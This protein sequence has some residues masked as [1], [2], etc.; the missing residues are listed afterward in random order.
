MTAAE[1]AYHQKACQHVIN[2]AWRIRCSAAINIDISSGPVAITQDAVLPWQLFSVPVRNPVKVGSS[3]LVH[4][5]LATPAHQPPAHSR[6]GVPLCCAS[7]AW[8]AAPCSAGCCHD[9][10]AQCKPSN[11]C[12][13]SL[14]LGMLLLCVRN[15]R[16]QDQLVIFMAMAEGTSS[17]LCNEPTL[18]T[19]TAIAVMQQLLPQV[20]FSI[21]TQPAD[22]SSHTSS[23]QL[24]LIECRGAGLRL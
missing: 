16:L 17:M 9:S 11:C 22:G 8:H 1:S 3:V 12:G 7:N 4:P 2:P 5:V 23:Q 15:C 14:P 20:H 19:R 10:A 6:Q 18:H 21:S 24:Y 13:P